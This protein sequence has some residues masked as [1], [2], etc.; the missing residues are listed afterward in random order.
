[1][2]GARRTRCWQSGTG[3]AR[4][5][6]SR[7]RS[8]CCV[9]SQATT[10]T[11]TTSSN[12]T[13]TLGA[14][15]EEQVAIRDRLFITAAV[16]TDQNNAFGTN[17]QSVWYP[18]ASISWVASEEGFFP[19]LGVLNQLRL[20]ASYGASGVQ[21]GPTQAVKTYGTSNVFFQGTQAVGIQLANPGNPDLK[22]ER[23]SEFEGGFDSRWWNDRISFDFT[24]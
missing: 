21:P 23:S 3:T 12:P 14:Y 7:H 4:T 1:M 8:T 20:R 11:V 2:V 17:F 10:F 22:P 19:K 24:Y 15:L 13:R 6:S 16:R 9:P 5:C 18:K